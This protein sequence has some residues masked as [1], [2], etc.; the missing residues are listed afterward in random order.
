VLVNRIVKIRERALDLSG[1]GASR[2]G[3]RWNN[4]GV[5]MLYTSLNVS[6]AMLEMLVHT[7]ESEVPP[8][9]FISRIQIADPAPIYKFPD[10]DLPKNWR[11]PDSL[12][13]KNIGDRLMSE[14]KYLGI[15][16]PSAVLPSEFNMLLNPLFPGYADLVKVIAIEP[17]DID[18]RLI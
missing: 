3:G 2:F 7:D 11:E 17:L 12:Q 14:R 13:L 6:L 8:K 16:V 4:E 18:L 9:M 1:R 10:A 15:R 5:C